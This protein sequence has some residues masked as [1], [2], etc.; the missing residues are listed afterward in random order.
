VDVATALDDFVAAV[1]P[2]VWWVH[3]V[4]VTAMASIPITAAIRLSLIVIRPAVPK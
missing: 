2:E 3:D 1:L 4:A